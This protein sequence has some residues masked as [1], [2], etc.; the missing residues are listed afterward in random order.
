LNDLDSY[1]KKNANLPDVIHSIK[2]E[3]L[4]FIE[5][6]EEMIPATSIQYQNASETTTRLLDFFTTYEDNSIN[7]Y[8]AYLLEHSITNEKTIHSKLLEYVTVLQGFHRWKNKKGLKE[9][10]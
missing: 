3:P 1:K 4:A 10:K 8:K 5:Y 6:M 7:G 2:V 9:V